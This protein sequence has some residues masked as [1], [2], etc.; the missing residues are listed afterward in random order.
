[1]PLP[2]LFLLVFVRS[3]FV[4]LFRARAVCLATIPLIFVF[5][6]STW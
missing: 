5:V 4:L 1:M 3:L 6:C 2:R